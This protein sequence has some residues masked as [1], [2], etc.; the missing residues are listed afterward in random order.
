MLGDQEEELNMETYL[1]HCEVS[2]ADAHDEV[3]VRSEKHEGLW[4]EN[5]EF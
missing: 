1:C 2:P 3:A 5:N 4:D